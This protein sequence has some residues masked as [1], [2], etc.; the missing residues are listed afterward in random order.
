MKD[1]ICPTCGSIIG[2]G[3]PD[4]TPE[5]IEAYNGRQREEIIRN[6]LNLGSEK[7]WSVSGMVRKA[8]L[9]GMLEGSKK[10]FARLRERKNAY[11]WSQD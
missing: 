11:D 6:I 5:E 2:G 7:G 1:E 8:Y 3:C 9:M 4:S 10:E